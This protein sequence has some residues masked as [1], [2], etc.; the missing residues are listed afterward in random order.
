MKKQIALLLNLI[1]LCGC[2]AVLF[3]WRSLWNPMGAGAAE[4]GEIAAMK[5]THREAEVPF[6][7]GLAFSGEQLPYDS[8]TSTFYLPLDRETEAW[9]GGELTSLDRSVRLLFEEEIADT[10]KQEAIRQGKAFRF[11]AVKDG[12]Y[13]ECSLVATGLPVIS[14]ET[15]ESA[16]TE[17]FGGSAFFWDNSTKINWTS[18]SILEAHIRGNTSRVYP[19][20]G[21]KLSLKK[22]KKNGDIVADK[23]SLFGLRTDDEWILN[24]MYTDSSKIRDKLNADLWSEVGASRPDFSSAYFGTRMTYVEVFFNHEYWGLYVLSEPVDSKQLN[25]TKANEGRAEEYSYKSVT[26][27]SLPTE[28]L[29]NQAEY[30]QSLD[31][32]ELKGKHETIGRSDW[33][34][35]LSYL[36]LRDMAFDTEFRETASEL[37]DREGALNVWMFLQ[38]VLGIDNRGKNMYY[39]AKQTERG[40]KIYFA[41]WDMDITWGDALSENENGGDIAWKVGLFTGLYSERINWAYGDRLIELDVDESK[42]YV[43]RTW[44]KLREDVFSEESLTGRIDDLVRQVQDSGA[45]ARDAARWP[46]SNSGQDMELFKRMAFYRL[47]ILDYYFNGNLEEY[48]GLGYE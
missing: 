47:G 41:P 48:L 22:Q 19:K 28:E 11:Y 6:F 10:D 34:P 31:G 35:L 42:D 27:Q 12:A 17:V 14:I 21:Y 23:K 3:C 9:E 26:P 18:S 24:A 29:L 2:L 15:A 37:T 1:L 45:Y 33:E 40:A 44:K 30:G 38:A 8:T 43:N 7:T 32:Y 36:R 39:V 46:E 25:R 20:K 4:A 5:E 13:Q 16:D